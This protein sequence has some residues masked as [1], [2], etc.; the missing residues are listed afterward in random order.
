MVVGMYIAKSF[1]LIVA[2]CLLFTSYGEIIE[3]F[4]TTSKNS[5]WHTTAP[6]CFAR[7]E[8]LQI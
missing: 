7:T 4:R 8:Y 3:S 6:E 5:D 1:Y 2:I